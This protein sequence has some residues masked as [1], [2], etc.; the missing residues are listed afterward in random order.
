MRKVSIALGLIAAV[1]FFQFCSS[2]KK[3]AKPVVMTYE[4]NV[5]P[6]IQESCTPCHITGKGNKKS[7]DNYV[8]AKDFA[9][10][11]LLRIQKNPTDKGYMPMRNP[12]LSDSAIAVFADWKKAGLLEK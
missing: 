9:D 11:I 3:A 10:D 1:V 8:N 5:L 7:L 2:S 4:K 6:L 12:K